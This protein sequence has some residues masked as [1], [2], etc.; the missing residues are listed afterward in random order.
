MEEGIVHKLDVFLID[1]NVS[2]KHVNLFDGDSY[3][4]N[5]HLKTATC[6]YITFILVLE[7]DWENIVEAKP[8]HMRL[9][10]KKIR[11]PLVAKTHTSLI[12]KVVIYV[13]EDA[14]ARFYSDVE[15]SYTDVYPTFL[16]NT[17]TRRYY[18]LD[19]GRTYTYIDPFISDGDKR[20]WLTREI[21]EAYDASTEEEEKEDDTEEDMDTVHLYCLEEEDEEKIADTGNDNQKDAED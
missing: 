12:Y 2:I 6:K 14:L 15:R 11:V 8:I 10:G 17:D 5:I 7:P 9:N 20:R 19:S 18:I 3:G 21:E 1:E 4:C 16:V 13:E